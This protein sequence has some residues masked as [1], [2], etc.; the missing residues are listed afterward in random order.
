MFRKKK[1]VIDY[2]QG[3]LVDDIFVVRFK[4]PV[5]EAKN[6]KYWFSL[7]LQDATGPIMLKYW[8]SEN[9]EEVKRLYDS[10]PE[11]DV[12]V[13]VVGVVSEYQGKLEISVDSENGGSIQVLNNGEF[14]VRDFIR[15][16]KRNPDEMMKELNEI[17]NSIKNEDIKKLVNTFF[18]DP[19]FVRRFK[20]S[21]GA[22]YKHHGWLHGL[23]EHTLT[24][25]KIAIDAAKNYPEVDRDLVIAGAILHDIGKVEEIE[26][27]LTIKVS[28]YGN[29]IGHI[30]IGAMMA[31]NRFKDIDAPEELKQKL[32]HIIISHH[33]IPSFGSPKS[34]EFPE[35]MIVAKADDMDAQ[36]TRMIELIENAK[37]EDSFIYDKG[38]GNVYLK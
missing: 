10:I 26:Y 21:P 29:L 11:T 18:G 34:P 32:V 35:A 2:K 36:V 16:S 13:R 7:R 23:L 25:T 17:I 19:N 33:S 28:D 6:G 31:A 8:G 22:M 30:T 1:G 12:V 9:E 5:S 3:D 27:G 37:T 38:L 20:Y 24:V 4:K 14:D 15:V